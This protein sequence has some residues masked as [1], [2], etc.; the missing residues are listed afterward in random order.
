[1]SPVSNADL[2]ALVRK[3]RVRS[4]HRWFATL[5]RIVNKP[6]IKEAAGAPK[7]AP[8]SPIPAHYKQDGF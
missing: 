5:Q 3:R 8:T 4:L 6:A 1:M 2:D 7:Y